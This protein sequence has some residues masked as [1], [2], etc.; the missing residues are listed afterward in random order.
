MLGTNTS[1]LKTSDPFRLHLLQG[2]VWHLITMKMSSTASRRPQKPMDVCLVIGANP[3]DMKTSD[4]FRL[5]LLQGK[6]GHL[7][8]MKMS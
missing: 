5:H 3:I 6:A 7:S 1:D 4:T 2:N 8:T